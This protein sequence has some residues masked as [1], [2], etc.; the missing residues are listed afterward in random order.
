MYVV[1]SSYFTL[2]LLWIAFCTQNLDF[3]VYSKVI[4]SVFTAIEYAFTIIKTIPIE[5]VCANTHQHSLPLG[6]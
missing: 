6:S 1:Y 4:H 5:A 2:S 3:I